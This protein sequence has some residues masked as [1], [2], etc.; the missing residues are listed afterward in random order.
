MK[1]LR[2]I[3]LGVQKRSWTSNRKKEQKRLR[4]QDLRKIS[5]CSKVTSPLHEGRGLPF[6]MPEGHFYIPFLPSDLR[7]IPLELCTKMSR[8]IMQISWLPQYITGCHPFTPQLPIFIVSLLLTVY[9][10]TP[11][12]FITL[13]FGFDYGTNPPLGTLIV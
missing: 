4:A 2:K 10:G 6:T 8:V 5:F 9:F 13:W 12:M 3:L 11:S 1:N 7:N